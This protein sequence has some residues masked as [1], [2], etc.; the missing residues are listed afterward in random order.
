MFSV[1]CSETKNPKIKK[2]DLRI[3]S[4]KDDRELLYFLFFDNQHTWKTL[5]YFWFEGEIKKNHWGV[6]ETK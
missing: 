2:Y 3:L 4:H 6:N 1:L 5:L